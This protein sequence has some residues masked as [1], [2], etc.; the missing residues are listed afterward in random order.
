[1]LSD[2]CEDTPERVATWMAAQELTWITLLAREELTQRQLALE[3]LKSLRGGPVE[4]DATAKP[5]VR[6]IQ[7]S[8]LRSAAS[9]VPRR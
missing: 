7:L 2:D 1:M 8:R 6:A 9:Y 4:F 3:Q 5:D